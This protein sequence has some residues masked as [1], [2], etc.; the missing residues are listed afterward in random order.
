MSWCLGACDNNDGCN[1]S[2][3]TKHPSG[4][5]S[6]DLV[7][8]AKL[9]YCYYNCGGPSKP[10]SKLCTD[11]LGECDNS[12]KLQW[13]VHRKTSWWSRNLWWLPQE[14]LSVH[15]LLLEHLRWWSYFFSY[16][17]PKK[18]TLSILPTHFTKH[19]ASVD[20]F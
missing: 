14:L 9:C 13:Q 18:V 12:C 11:G 19:P 7:G 2:C 17:T 4:Q 16:L 1:S 5:G 3:N 20:V 8:G 6:C 10:P 15:I